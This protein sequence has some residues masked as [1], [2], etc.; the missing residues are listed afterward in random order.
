M[1]VKPSNK[2][3]FLTFEGGEGV[4]KSTQIRYLA[5]RLESSG[6]AVL[7]TREPGGAPGL[8]AQASALRQLL[9]EGDPNAWSPESEALLNYAQRV[10]HVRRIIK[11][12][13]S[14]GTWVLCDR[15]ADSTMA[16]QGYG[17]RLGPDFVKKLHRLVLGSFAPDL[18]LVFDLPLEVG[19]KRALSRAG[20]ETRFE[21]MGLEFHK[22]LRQGF[23]A[24]ARQ[25][26]KRC[27]L[28]DASGDETTVAKRIERLVAIRF[29]VKVVA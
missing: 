1:T 8:L 5:A 19:L 23:R 18:T 26:P 10:E 14:N 27:R 7:V 2:G 17:H 20:A 6:V 4:G 29:G 28:V 11:P 15:F 16:Y 9:V 13:L 3:R 25:N 21:R 24:I 22:R 12:A